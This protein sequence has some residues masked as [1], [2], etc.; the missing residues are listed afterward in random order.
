[1]K[2]RNTKAFTL[3]ELIIVLAIIGILFAMI[4]PVAYKIK[5]RQKAVPPTTAQEAERLYPRHCGQNVYHF[6][7]V[8]DEFRKAIVLFIEG[9]PNLELVTIVSDVEQFGN[10]ESRYGATKGHTAIF[11][12]KPEKLQ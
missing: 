11:H 10:G 8:G 9:N 5:N 1:M 2:N 3:I 7:F 12:K 4:L 6:P